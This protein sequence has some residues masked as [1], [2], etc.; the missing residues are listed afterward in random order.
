M[1]VL[2]LFAAMNELSERMVAAAQANDW[3]CLAALESE[4]AA[5]RTE[6]MK[7]EPGG[8]SGSALSAADQALKASLIARILE[9]DRE[10]RRHVEPWMASTRKL[11]SGTARDRAVRTAYGALAP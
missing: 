5:L 6:I 1:N 9:N 2:T 10:V 8:R 3:D 7:L 4:Q 11:L